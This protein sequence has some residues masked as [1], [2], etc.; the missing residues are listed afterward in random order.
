VVGGGEVLQ[1]VF[2]ALACERMLTSTV[3]SG[4]LYYCTADGGFTERVVPLDE[5]SREAARAVAE[6][7]DHG[8]AEGFLPAAPRREGCRYCDYRPVC[9]PH[10]ELRVGRKPKERLAELLR[11]RDMR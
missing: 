11:L 2:Y 5:S 3:E 7:I 10:E 1:P 8:L 4:R 6:T 9:G